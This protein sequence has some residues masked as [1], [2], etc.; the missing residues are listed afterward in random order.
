MNS[1]KATVISIIILILALFP[2]AL[3]LIGKD[4]YSFTTEKLPIIQNTDIVIHSKPTPF[5]I[6]MTKLLP[7]TIHLLCDGIQE[8]T[9]GEYY[10]M[11]DAKKET[12]KLNVNTTRTMIY[13]S[14]NKDVLVNSLTTLFPQYQPKVLHSRE[15]NDWCFTF[16]TENKFSKENVMKTINRLQ[17]FFP[18]HYRFTT[19]T[20][21]NHSTE[22]NY[23]DMN[24]LY[25]FVLMLSEDESEL[26]IEDHK[27]IASSKQ[28]E[29]SLIAYF[30]YILQIP[31][32]T[33]NNINLDYAHSSGF[34]DIELDN[35]MR[36]LYIEQMFTTNTLLQSFIDITTAET[37]V[38]LPY[39][40]A[41]KATSLSS[42]YFNVH[43]T[44]NLI[45]KYKQSTTLMTNAH[46]VA[47]SE[48]FFTILFFPIQHKIA[49]LTPLFGP[50]ILLFIKALY[51]TYKK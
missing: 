8:T 31:T 43:K 12:P 41:Q 5:C 20:Q 37:L 4:R 42:N 45:D 39:S 46:D 49:C 48:D 33:N 26:I 22:L 7:S 16:A 1:R 50:V 38:P 21:K 29:K 28:P 15:V 34:L 13:H 27:G 30:R 32:I 24:C 9:P 17:Y 18:L 35:V 51:R 14:L 44:T 47:Y 23:P 3:F 19:N 10:L 6:E 2:F 40:L 11:I 36:Q 25:R